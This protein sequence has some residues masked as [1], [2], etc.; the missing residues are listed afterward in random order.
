MMILERS[1]SAAGRAAGRPLQP[2]VRRPSEDL[3]LDIGT[4]QITQTK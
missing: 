3:L 2:D 4:E 1:G